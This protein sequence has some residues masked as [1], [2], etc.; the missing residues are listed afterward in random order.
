[1][2]DTSNPYDWKHYKTVGYPSGR[3]TIT[4]AVLSPDNKMLAYSSIASTVYVSNTSSEMDGVVA[5]DFAAHTRGN[6]DGMHARQFGVRRFLHPNTYLQVNGH[7]I[8][9]EYMCGRY[10]QFDFQGTGGKW[11]QVPTIITSMS[12]ILKPAHQCWRCQDTRAR[13]MR[14]VSRMSTPRISSF[15]GPTTLP[16]K[17][18]TGEVWPQER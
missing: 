4:D 16:S 11:L 14:F 1:M 17:F 9:R 2:Y 6:R 8:L 7:I 3:W 10:G 5:L 13:L 18:G 12:T 15:R